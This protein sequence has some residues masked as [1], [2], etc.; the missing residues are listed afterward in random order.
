M[1]HMRARPP[2]APAGT[3]PLAAARRAPPSSPRAACP[4][5]SPP[6]TRCR[7]RGASRRSAC[8][9]CCPW[10]SPTSRRS[11]AQVRRGW[12]WL[13]VVCACARAVDQ[14]DGGLQL[15]ALPNKRDPAPGALGLLVH[16]SLSGSLVAKE[17]AARCVGSG[18]SPAALC[19][20]AC[21][22]CNAPRVR[23]SQC[24][25]SLPHPTTRPGR[26]PTLPPPT[27]TASRSCG[28]A[29]RRS[30]PRS[31]AAAAAAAPQAATAP[32]AAARPTTGAATS[33][34]ARCRTCPSAGSCRRGGRCWCGQGAQRPPAC[35][36]AAISSLPC[37]FCSRAPATRNCPC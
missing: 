16:A 1:C 27:P 5:W 20:F 10:R 2:P 26:S 6:R 11:S 25:V 4:R 3:S 33:R 30:S 28:R 35:D 29:P 12:Q 14:A 31:C 17:Y 19:A 15:L 9:W 34:R 7:A 36:A 22:P 8:C 13:S 24:M 37:P 18:R 23:V 21:N 32:P